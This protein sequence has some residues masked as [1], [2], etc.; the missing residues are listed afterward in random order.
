MNETIPIGKPSPRPRECQMC[1]AYTGCVYAKTKEAGFVRVCVSCAEK[2][3]DAD[4]LIM[5][6]RIILM[7]G[8][9]K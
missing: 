2:M 5:P 7:N 8:H 3:R 6:D 1:G 4:L 9:S